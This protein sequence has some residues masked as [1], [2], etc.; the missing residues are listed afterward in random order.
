MQ[1]TFIMVFYHRQSIHAWILRP[2]AKDDTM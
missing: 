2:M 1:T